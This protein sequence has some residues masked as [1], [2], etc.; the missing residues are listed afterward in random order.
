MSAAIPRSAVVRLEGSVVI[1]AAIGVGVGALTDVPM[2]VLI[3][4]SMTGAIFVVAGWILLWPMDADA[5]HLNA[6]R[7]AFNPVV[8]EL[9]VVAA[10]LGALVSVVVL[11][12]R[13]RTHADPAAAAAALAG[14]SWPGPGCT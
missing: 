7:E 6:H 9:V 2:G 8:E 3:G 4:I 5:T 10:A 1:G 13:N 12:I 14:F 11:L